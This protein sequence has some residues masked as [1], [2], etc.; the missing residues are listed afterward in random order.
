MRFAQFQNLFW[1][2]LAVPLTAFFIWAVR[3]ENARLRKFAQAELLS[4]IAQGVSL[5][6]Q[7]AKNILPAGVFLFSILAL[8]RPQWG[9]EWQEVKRQGIDIIIAVDTSKSML[10]SDVKPNRLERTRLAVKDLVK[11]LKGDRVG[12]IAFAGDAFMVCPLTSDY[13]GFLLSLDDVSVGTIPRGGTN[14]SAALKEAMEGYDNT[15]AKYKA[16]IIV[17]DGENLEGDPV[18]LAKEAK[19][20]EVKVFTVG[21]GTPEGELVQVENEAGQ[22]EF[23]KDGNGNFVKSRLNEGL[24]QEIALTT[25]GAYVRASGAEFGLDL[26]YDRELSRIEKR[27]IESRVEKKYHERFQYPLAVAVFLLVLEKCLRPAWRKNL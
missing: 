6:R 11:K 14:I 16:V 4:E 26:I 23:L 10:T 17:T 13:S 3:N 24:L 21:I 7:W 12:L 8:A 22:K 1:I 2:F 15:P 18:A 25:G 19:A 5:F 27:E 9:F 20:K